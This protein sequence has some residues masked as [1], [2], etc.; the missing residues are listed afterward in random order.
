MHRSTRRSRLLA[1]FTLTAFAP[2]AHADEVRLHDGR[3][4]VGTVVKKGDS[5]EVSTRDGVVVVQVQEVQSHLDDKALRQKLAD[6]QQ[7]LPDTPWSHLQLAIEARGYGLEPELWRH[8]DRA[9]ARADAAPMSDG[10]Q[11]QLRDFLARL[12][13]ELLP[14]SLRQAATG[15]RVHKLLDGVHA[16]T[17]PGKAAA[18]E[19]VLVRLPDA[20]QDLRNEARRNATPRQRIAALTA[21][22]R[23]ALAGNDRFVLRTAIL[24]G[25]EQVRDAALALARPT[26][27]G[28][29]IAYMAA[30]LEHQNAKVRMRTADALG[31]LGRPEAMPLLVQAAPRAGT[32]L[33]P[34]GGGGQN[35][36]RGHIAIINQQAYIRD[37]DVEVAQAAFIADPKVDVLQS[38]VVLDVT[39]AGTIEVRTILLR[40]RQA[41]KQLAA[42]DPGEDPRKWPDWLSRQPAPGGT[43]KVPAP[44]TTPTGR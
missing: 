26:V 12:E 11:R 6:R 33:V 15:K 17:S 35:G 36:D 38:G 23:R 31:G 19:E 13:P 22:Q 20:D 16:S 2:F 27:D 40:Y 29:D 43:D 18:I 32:G 1:L 5:L 7:T 24:D 30:G 34:A 44:A 28:D 25:S 37:F 41:L 39:V 21:L 14:R 3:I 8:L 4:L 42:N 9:V 10:L